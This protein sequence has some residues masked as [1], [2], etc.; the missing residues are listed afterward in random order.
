[1]ICKQQSPF[2]AVIDKLIKNFDI[3]IKNTAGDLMLERFRQM[4]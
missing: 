3:V 1:M 4:S 2:S